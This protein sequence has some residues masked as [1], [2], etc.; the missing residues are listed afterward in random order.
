MD[1]GAWW[2]TVYGVAE[3][4]TQLSDYY[5][6]T[7]TGMLI[8]V[9]TPWMLSMIFL[10]FFAIIFFPLRWTCIHF[11]VWKCYLRKRKVA[12]T[13][14]HNL[15]IAEFL[16]VNLKSYIFIQKNTQLIKIHSS[17]NFHAQPDQEKA[18]PS[19]HPFLSSP[20]PVGSTILTPNTVY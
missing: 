14:P 19:S 20:T 7:C 9:Q 5:T 10:L 18:A 11:A 2:A 13:F 16:R 8:L 3:S 1:R 15:W 17:V 6:H 12:R 4:Q